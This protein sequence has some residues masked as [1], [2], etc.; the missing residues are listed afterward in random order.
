MCFAFRA[1]SLLNKTCF[2]NRIKCD[3]PPAYLQH[4]AMHETITCV[5]PVLCFE[6]PVWH[7]AK[8]TMLL[9]QTKVRIQ[10][11][12]QEK[13][14]RASSLS[15]RIPIQRSGFREQS[16]Q[17]KKPVMSGKNDWRN[18]LEIFSLPAVHPRTEQR[19]RPLHPRTIDLHCGADQG[20]YL[21]AN[22]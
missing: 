9:E 5:V 12:L 16:C 22:L 1:T 14:T 19:A 11:H 4:S 7:M 20:P 13:R 2:T 18:H 6:N 10:H 17:T 15:Q 21:Q 3:K 8:S